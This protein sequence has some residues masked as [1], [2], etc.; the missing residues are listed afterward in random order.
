[1]QLLDIKH[2]EI[3]C[4]LTPE[5]ALAVAA[6]FREVISHDLAQHGD[7]VLCAVYASLFESAALAAAAHSYADLPEDWGIDKVRADLSPLVLD[8]G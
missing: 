1:M 6:A 7:H 5:D 4:T 2:R 3:A 8:R